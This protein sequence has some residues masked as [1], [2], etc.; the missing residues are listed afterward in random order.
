MGGWRRWGGWGEGWGGGG[1]GGGGGVSVWVGCQCLPVLF[2]LPTYLSS[3]QFQLVY[4]N[5]AH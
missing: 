3:F 4:N 2:H 5:Y 1:G